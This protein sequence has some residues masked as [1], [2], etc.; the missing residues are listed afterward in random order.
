MI[1]VEAP[2]VRIQKH[3]LVVTLYGD[4]SREPGARV[5]YG[6][7][8]AAL[9][10]HF[11][12]VAVED[13]TLRGWPRFL[14]GLKVFH[15][16]LHTWKERFY[17]NAAAFT[18]RSQRLAN[19][20]NKD[21][22]DLIFQV[23]VLFDSRWESG[24]SLPSVIYT[25]YTAQL[26]A[27]KIDAGRS[28]FMPEQRAQWIALETRAYQNAAHIFTRGE[29][30]RRSLIE[31]YGLPPERIT[32]VGGGLNL[33]HLPEAP[34]RSLEKSPEVLFIGKEFFRKG[35]DRLLEAFQIVHQVVPSARLIMLSAF[36]AKGMHVP[37]Y[38]RWVEPTWNRE[39][40][41]R[42]YRE[43]DVFVLPSRLETWGDV[44]LEAMSFGLP[45]VGVQGDGRE[46]MITD[47]VNGFVIPPD[48]PAVLAQVLVRLLQDPDLRARM[49]Q[50][51]R[52]RVETQFTW[53]H[54]VRRMIPA[55][56]SVFQVI[57]SVKGGAS[58]GR[59]KNI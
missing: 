39:V 24:R 52:R 29:F 47:G 31:D 35:G 26:S 14:N 4:P 40:V 53:D 41:Q 50:E 3:R 1:L 51:G 49:G 55:I 16:S 18:T 48:D 32:S 46:E 9:E 58:L 23:G 36:P 45:C 42:L 20:L 11:Q 54:V 15:P 38:V 6:G 33:D 25:D 56:E 37:E 59:T 43:A 10:Q 7:L 17:K 27:Q 28:P 19:R 44:F 21:Q 8:I 2:P 12:V 34:R 57:P 22:A 30:V 13:A 5:K